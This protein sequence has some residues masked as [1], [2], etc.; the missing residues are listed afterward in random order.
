M[1][2]IEEYK[3]MKELALY[4]MN[5]YEELKKKLE[6]GSNGMGEDSRR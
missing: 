3:R 1:I 6:V 5:E 4:W 2:S